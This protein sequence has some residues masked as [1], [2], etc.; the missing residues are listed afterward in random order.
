MS[1]KI[2]Q[3][4]YYGNSNENNYPNK[5]TAQEMRSGSIFKDYSPIT[6]ITIQATAGIKFYLNNSIKPITIMP[7]NEE[8]KT[9]ICSIETKNMM[10]ITFLN[11][12]IV[13]INEIKDTEEGFIF[14][15][16]EYEK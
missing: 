15:D 7:T 5:I 16:I 1:K 8:V 12:D 3:F 14:I 11:F 4:R 2:Q 6:K 10:P 9:G 13:S